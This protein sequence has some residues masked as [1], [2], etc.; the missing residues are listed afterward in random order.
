MTNP[1]FKVLE[2]SNNYVR[3]KNAVKSGEGPVSVFGLGESQRMHISSA[4]QAGLGTTMLFISPSA[5]AAKQAYE[6]ISAYNSNVLLFPA[7]EVPLNARGIAQSQELS[8]QRMKVL[9]ALVSGKTNITVVASIEAV[10]QQLVMPEAIAGCS[11]SLKVG[12]IISPQALLKLFA[13]AGYERTDVCEGK[14]QFAARGGC[15]DVFP[16]TTQNPIRI[17]FFD[18]EI[19]TM[20]E[21]DPIT[22]RSIQNI[23]EVYIPCA[24]ELPLTP[25]LCEN[26]VNA[27]KSHAHFGQELEKIKNGILP[28]NAL[29]FIPLFCRERYCLID[30]LPKDGMILIDEPARIDESAKYVYTSFMNELGDVLAA[31]EGHPLQEGLVNT[32]TYVINRLNTSQTVMLFAFSRAYALISPKL[33]IKAETVPAPRYML[34]V[35]NLDEALKQDI[36]AWKKKQ[37][38]ILIY[39]GSHAQR[40]QDLLRELDIDAP[41]IEKAERDILPRELSI[42]AETIPMGFE[43]PDISLVVLSEHELFGAEFRLRPT[44]VKRNKQQLSVSELSVGDLV[45]H[46]R[47]GI[48]RFDGVTTLKV[49]GKTRDYIEL[50]YHGGNK[51]YIPTDQ[52]DRIQKY[53]GGDAEKQKLSRLGSS[54]WQKTVSRTKASVKQLAFDLLKLYGD[55]SR[56]KGYKFSPDTDWQRRLELS[57][58]FTETADQLTSIAEIKKDMES[59]RIMDRLLCGDVGYGKTEVALRAAFK[60]VMDGKQCAFLVPTTI[61]AQ[62]H[63]NTLTARYADFPVNVALLCRFKTSAEVA[64]I[65]RKLKKGEIDIIIGTHSILAKDVKFHDLGLLIID[66]EQRFGVNHKEQIKNMKLNVD[67]L[68]LSATPIPRTLH[69]SMSGIRDMSVIDTPPEERFPIQTYVLEYSDRVI[70]EAILKELGRG[71]QVFYLYNNVKTMDLFAEKL[72]SLIPEATVVC[73]HG[74]M[75]EQQLEKTMLDFIDNKFNVLLCSTIIESGIDIRNANTLIVHNADCFGLSQ[76][77]QLRGRIGRG[78][79]LAYAYFTYEQDKI[80]SEV[81]FKRLS[82]IKQFTQFGAGFRI[83]MRDLEIRGAGDILGAEQHGHMQAVGYEMYC[84]LINSAIKQAKGEKDIPTVETT[85]EVGIDAFIPSKYIAREETRMQMYKRIA[86]IDNIDDYRD[87]QDEFIDRFGDMPIPVQNLL[88]ISL[89]KAKAAKMSIVK[90][91]A[92]RG[93]AGL[94]I[95][96]NTNIDPIK[97]ID[98]ISKLNNASVNLA[99]ETILTFKKR[100]E[101][102]E[103][104]FKLIKSTIDSLSSICIENF[105]EQQDE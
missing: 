62:Q 51:L 49:D 69:M 42:V 44:S 31:D 82:A 41:I 72:S 29:S 92:K 7:R 70:R 43:Y 71:G 61:L 50:Y 94:I 84:R 60:C 67:V 45:V 65:K 10:M 24:G 68:T 103:N 19:D 98:M 5:L 15:I 18:D 2:K 78:S 28:D 1:L 57:F 16:V 30:Y 75:P 14:G 32:P 11:H 17:E 34:G 56:R 77:Y 20:R 38:S 53:I 27:L 39:A 79:R 9:S 35:E 37:Y 88:E 83:A 52:L 87:V 25:E 104:M 101:E 96:K 3:L 76:L 59:D 23:M 21:Y 26:A 66:E 55:R 74:Q 85:M 86:S 46:E 99:D 13:Q 64:E 36:I 40:V 100:D 54:E 105:S 63:Y 80:L 33:I 6:F 90:V 47:H 91:T 81:A 97:L 8:A 4:L 73:A 58:P 48:G 89:Y 93:E 12:M 22:Q 95:T 102:P